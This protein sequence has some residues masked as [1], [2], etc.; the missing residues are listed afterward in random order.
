SP[1]M[2]SSWKRQH[3]RDI[4]RLGC[5]DWTA[6]RLVF[7]PGS[8][9][10]FEHHEHSVRWRVF[11]YGNFADVY[12]A[13]FRLRDKPFQVGLRLVRERRHRPQFGD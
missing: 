7:P 8:Q 2:S 4:T 5:K 12:M 9:L 11:L 1:R 10:S 13:L 3:T 6:L